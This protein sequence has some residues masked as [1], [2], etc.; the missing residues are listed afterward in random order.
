MAY[1]DAQA[2]LKALYAMAVTQGGYFTTKQAGNAGYT[3]QHIDY[4]VSVGNFERVKR[5]L[6]RLPTIPR[7]EHDEFIRLSLW[8]RGRD[9][10]PQAVVSHESALAL[11]ELS[12]MLPGK[13]HLTVPR[14]FRKQP[15]RNCQL[16]KGELGPKDVLARSGF[17]VT[18]PLR[19]LIDVA[20]DS[21]VPTEQLE[22]AIQDAVDKGMVT[23]RKLK[24]AAAQAGPDRRLNAAAQ[25]ALG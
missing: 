11:H 6:F 22:L 23:R 25:K 10:A 12:D 9:D 18:T 16:H 3:K 2:A 13:V 4:H 8:S 21:T 17:R 5:G 7:D 1:R 24:D 15:P 20:A 14:S 19:T